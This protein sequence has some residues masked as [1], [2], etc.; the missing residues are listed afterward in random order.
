MI[1]IKRNLTGRFAKLAITFI[2]VGLLVLVAVVATAD[3]VEVVEVPETN[4]STIFSHPPVTYDNAPFHMQVDLIELNETGIRSTSVR[5]N[6]TA[7][8]NVSAV[9]VPEG[10]DLTFYMIMIICVMSII[11]V[12]EVGFLCLYI[13]L[14]AYQWG[15]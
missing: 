15:K 10:W 2:A 11:L 5:G 6:I 7:F 13:G 9:V 8:G 12:L 14:K 3:A 1:K 4:L